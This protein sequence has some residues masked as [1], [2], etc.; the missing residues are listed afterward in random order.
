MKKILAVLLAL[1]MVISLTACGGN[2]SGDNENGGLKKEDYGTY[3]LSALTGEYW[4]SQF[5]EIDQKVVKELIKA[6][7]E[8]DTLGKWYLGEESY[9]EFNGNKMYV[10]VQKDGIIEG[11]T[12]EDKTKL[13]N[14][15]FQ[16]YTIKLKDG[17]ISATSSL[18]G[19]ECIIQYEKAE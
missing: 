19:K 12:E 17:I 14:M 13:S 7:S 5:G 4:D 18:D 11:V 9:F 6:Y 15:F 1:T 10:T 2:A 8:K 3:K 16:E